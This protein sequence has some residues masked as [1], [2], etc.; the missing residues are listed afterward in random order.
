MST[1]ASTN[2]MPS[3]KASVGGNVK[4]SASKRERKRARNARVM[5]A[6]QTY[7]RTRADLFVVVEVVRL[8]V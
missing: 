5:S 6:R 1:S 3:V 7:T 8:R 2:M 4:A